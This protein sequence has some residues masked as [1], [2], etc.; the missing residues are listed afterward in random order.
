M[1]RTAL[2]SGAG[3]AGT[4]A[5]YWLA[6]HGWETTIVERSGDLRSSGN[7]VDV[8]GPALPVTEQ[9]GVL[10]GL[11]AV[12]T[13]A[14]G[15]RILDPTG[16]PIARLPMGSE[17]GDV[18]VMRGDLARVLWSATE[19]DTELI[20]DDTITGL[21]QDPEGVDATF[22]R[23]GPRRFD[24][25]IG[26]DGLHSTVRRIAFGP[27]RE[28]SD[29]LGLYVA[30]VQFG[31]PP[32]N[33]DE[34][35]LLN[36][37]GRLLG[38]HPARGEA[39]VAFIF[40]HPELTGVDRHDSTAQKQ[41]ITRAYQG[42]GWRVPELLDR[43]QEADD[44]YFDAVTR[45]RLASWSRGRIVLLGDAA[46]CVSLF[47]DG[48]TM[49][50]AGAHQLASAL[51]ASP[52]DPQAA[53]RRYESNHR[54]LTAQKQRRVHLAATLLV[55]AHRLTLATRNSVARVLSHA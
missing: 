39:G 38:L 19:D 48:S 7:P 30:T 35:E 49:A 47:G 34:V 44:I 26:A 9:M 10:P 45:V 18:E 4:T 55:P 28:F 29:Y 15:M 21:E 33:P 2:I 54:K 23:S 22:E 52:G 37:P 43:L 14:K 13:H 20:L 6:R 40:R 53:L 12:A 50:I 42:I 1:K 32:A 8:R 51:A 11:R 3:I 41:V 36:V 25:V 24:L 16:R 17:D 31:G 46:S 27:E 5:A